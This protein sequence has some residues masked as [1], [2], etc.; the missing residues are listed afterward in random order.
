MT[1]PFVI[2]GVA[3]AYNFD[4]KN[5]KH[6]GADGNPVVSHSWHKATVPKPYQL[7]AQ[8]WLNDW[9]GLEFMETMLLESATDMICMHSVPLFDAFHDGLVS[10]DKG[11]ALKRDYPDRIIWYGAID[12]LKGPAALEDLQRQVED[13][14]IDGIKLYPTQGGRYW[15]MDDR[16][17][18]FPVFERCERLGLKNVA[19]HK[20]LP[21]VG[22][23]IESMHVMDVGAA[24]A[25]FPNL[26]FQ[27]VHAGMAFMDETKYLVMG[28]PNIYATLEGPMLFAIVNPT[29]FRAIMSD[30]LGMAGPGKLIYS[31]GAVNQHP[32]FVLDAFS[33][34]EMDSDH[35]VQLTDEVRA[36]ILGGTIARL[37]GIDVEA[38]RRTLAGDRFSAELARTGFREP[39]STYRSRLAAS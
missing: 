13:L 37:H 29:A 18:A 2:D 6:V 28:H 33:R 27:I 1:R 20:A 21:A 38:R 17:A 34:M 11:A 7:T 39:F 32:K 14:H 31:S 35:P 26:N 4:P 22:E 23:P 3:H 30:F 8:E 15:L 9:K 36:Q 16:E 19:V 24:A 25:A 10:I 5:W 12:V